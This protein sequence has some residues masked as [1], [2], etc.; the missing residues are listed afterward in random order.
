MD[1]N[2]KLGM[3]DKLLI[4]F[5][6]CFGTM[7]LTYTIVNYQVVSM[8]TQT[9]QW[10]PSLVPTADNI[11]TGYLGQPTGTVS[12]TMSDNRPLTATAPTTAAPNPTGY[13]T[14]TAAYATEQTE[15]STPWVIA[16]A[17]VVCHQICS[18]ISEGHFNPAV[19][20]AIMSARNQNKKSDMFCLYWFPQFLGGLLA[21][22][23]MQS[24]I[25]QVA[26]G[27]YLGTGEW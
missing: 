5:Y 24:T 4:M 17:L 15:L 21:H 20:L 6:E 22:F 10:I 1:S 16:F 18:H 7:V 27:T 14:W 12:L 26:Y 13:N 11:P 25:P 23:L 2:R 19:T 9:H 8:R 3:G